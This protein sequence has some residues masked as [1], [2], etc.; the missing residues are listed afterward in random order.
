MSTKR[1]SEAMS[2]VDD[3]YYD[4]AVSYKASVTSSH[5]KRRLPIILVAALMTIFLMGAGVVVAIYGDSIQ[6]WFGYYWEAIT[7]QNMSE[8]H[9]VLIDHLSQEIEKSQTIGDVT[10]T[11]DSATVGDDNFFLL[12]K[13]DGIELSKKHSYI[14][15]QIYMEVN[16][17]PV[18]SGGMGGYG[19]Q[20]H[21]L[22]GD[23]TALLLIEFSYTNMGGFSK[24]TRPLEV[25]LKL[26]DF[27]QSAHSDKA[28]VLAEGE[29]NFTF[30]ID[31]SQPPASIWLPDTEVEA[32]DLDKQKL[33]PV[34]ITNIELTN[35]GLRFKYDY[36]EG[37]LSIEPHI[38]VVLKNG[39]AIGASGGSSVSDEDGIY[40]YNSYQWSVPVNLDEVEYV[41]IGETKI[42]V[43]NIQ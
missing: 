10:V 37:T 8:E 39:T 26:N 7:G 12:L 2:E 31:R 42:P 36:M 22:D 41:K 23:G 6:S 3:K 38:D 28:K 25:S 5:A 20:Y 9:T 14:F 13:I 43:P 18:T 16:P 34:T 17:D 35:T 33:V 40:L 27:T 15:D 21:G 11:V 30:S 32:M 4:E 1:F 19:F 29:W 24:D